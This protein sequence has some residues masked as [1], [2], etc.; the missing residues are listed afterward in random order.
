[1]TDAAKQIIRAYYGHAPTYSYFVGCSTGGEQG[2]MEAQ[3][4]P[5][6]YDGIVAG[7]PANTRTH[8]HMDILWNS[9]A[10]ISH[11]LDIS[12]KTN[13]SYYKR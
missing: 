1:M 6:D 3:R 13:C 7:A 11:R 2:L 9:A 12:S 4:F 10:G 8:L 5:D